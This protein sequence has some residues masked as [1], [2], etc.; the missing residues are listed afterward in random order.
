MEL[1]GRRPRTGD[2][3]S[4]RVALALPISE[5]LG[6]DETRTFYRGF[7][8]IEVSELALP[9]SAAPHLDFDVLLGMDFLQGFHLTVYADLFIL[10]NS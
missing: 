8:S 4:Y 1:G 5:P 2:V 10:S 9:E 6:S 7:P 3:P